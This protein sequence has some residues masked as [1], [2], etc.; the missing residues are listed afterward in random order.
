[1]DFSLLTVF[2]DFCV[3]GE[4]YFMD[5]C[6]STP[7]NLPWKLSLDTN[8]SGGV[9]WMQMGWIVGVTVTTCIFFA[10]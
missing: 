8:N 7:P 6:R 3:G 1:M 9:Y 10:V 5:L 2:D 4:W